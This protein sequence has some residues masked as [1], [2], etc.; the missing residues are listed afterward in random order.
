MMF[1]SRRAAGVLVLFA[2][3]SLFGQSKPDFS[4][5]WKLNKSK[6][7][8]GPMADRVPEDFTVK[9][10]HK[11]PELKI[12]QP[13][14]GGRVQESTVSTDGKP[15]EST[16]QGPMGEIKTKAVSKWDGPILVMDVNREFGGNSMT[17]NDKW[18]LSEDGKT[19]TIVRKI[20]GPMG[21]LEMKQVLDKQ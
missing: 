8:L 13:G 20:S 12:S 2:A 14:M 19:L 10:D 17:Q 11:E 5:N 21:E 3:T 4:G 16:G 15:T 1:L 6:S 9:I 18:T 7:D